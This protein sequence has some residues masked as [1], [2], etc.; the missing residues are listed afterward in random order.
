MS[1]RRL[2]LGRLPTD[3]QQSDVQKLFDG[4]GPVTECRVMTGF[5]FVEFENPKD[6][7]DVVQKFNGTQFMGNS[8]IVE[9]A[10]DNRRRDER[11]RD[12]PPRARRPPPGHRVIVTGLSRDTSWQDLKDFGRDTGGQITFA[13]IDYPGSGILEYVTQEDADDAVR[14]LDGKDLRGVSVRV[15]HGDVSCSHCPHFDSK[16]RYRDRSPRRS[17]SPPRRYDERSPPRRDRDDFRR[18]DRDRE[19]DRRDDR[20]R[21][22]EYDRR[23]DR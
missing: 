14:K 4:Y 6:A 16:D 5:G 7:E 23:D 2:Y 10:R 22:R 8:I 21:H 9:F 17:R 12:P 19:F 3:A 20:D 13:D 15:E 11:R 1:S 18:D